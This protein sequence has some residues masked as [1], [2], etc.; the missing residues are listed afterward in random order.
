MIGKYSA[1]RRA[2]AGI[3]P[4]VV[5]RIL[6]GLCAAVWLLLVGMSVA[7]IVALVDL[8][9]GFH[10][11]A[12]SPHTTWALYVIIAVSAAVIVAAIPV[13]I[14]ARRASEV[15]LT[16]TP[17]SGF[18]ASRQSIQASQLAAHS[19][20]GQDR[21]DRLIA[22]GLAAGG[23]DEAVDRVWLRGT[24]ILMGTMGA[25]LVAVAVAT[26]LMAIGRDGSS[27]TSYAIAGAITM[28]IPA[29]PWR[30]N[31]HLR[32]LIAHRPSR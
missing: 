15:E 25:A 7:A 16:A 11:M 20:A 9:R 23:S 28:A 22:V 26:Y 5:D 29:I 18:R 13:L 8:G 30:H 19:T 2:G 14:R 1:Y 10:Q 31:R 24:I 32:L 21:T 17:G 27:W 12:R 3:S 6:V 4:H